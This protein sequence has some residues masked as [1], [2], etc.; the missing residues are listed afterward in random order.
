M[1][2]PSNQH[3]AARRLPRASLLLPTLAL[4]SL[5]AAGFAAGL[6]DNLTQLECKSIAARNVY[7]L[8]GNNVITQVYGSKQVAQA[9][10][11][12]IDGNL[13]GID[14]RPSQSSPPDRFSTP[15]LYGLTDTGKIY[16]LNIGGNTA[17]AT[18]VSS[19]TLRFD[20][21]FQALA[22]FNPV[23]D[24]L[25]VIGSNDQNYAVVNSNGNLNVTAQQ[26]A[27][28]YAAGDPQAGKDPNLTGGAYNNNLAGAATTIFYALDYAT[29]S[30]VTI[31][32]ITNGSSATGGGRLKTIGRLV[33][34]Q[35]RP[36]NILPEAGI[37]VY[38]DATLGNGAL[39]SS[40]QTLYFV[41]LANVNINLPV[42]ST[43]NVVVKQLA[44]PNQ[45]AQL[46]PQ[47]PGVFMDIA[48]T[49]SP[50]L[51]LAAD[52]AVK[53]TPN[54]AQFIN[55]Q[56]YTFELTVTNQGPDSQDGITFSTGGF[57]FRDPVV[58]TTQGTC[59]LGPTNISDVAQFG[60]GFSCN[61]GTLAFG[62][63]A[64]VTVSVSRLGDFFI[65]RDRVEALFIAQGTGPGISLFLAPNDPDSTNNRLTSTV[66]ISR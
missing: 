18:L 16:T 40:G 23:V 4:C 22:D 57:P 59:S 14:F 42:G 13:I 62:A 46:I 44:G 6:C 39:I 21:G 12:D 41:N 26:T 17:T 2:H 38:T 33:D 28:T 63:S 45:P 34:T 7:A 54:L 49:P 60:R 37:D 47:T 48:S 52:L 55:G 1:K 8:L 56:R 36:I 29:D 24:A 19:L 3:S 35:G 51:A 15:G 30:L 5:P 20:G 32:D 11:K 50:V 27:I 66:F 10:V 64:T 43:Q 9:P 25:R 53:Q 61:I 58:S 65:G 31:A